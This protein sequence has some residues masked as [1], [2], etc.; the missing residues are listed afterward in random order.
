MRKNIAQQRFGR[1]TAIS[2]T[3]EKKWG[4]FLWHCM[5][6]CGGTHIAAVNSLIAGLVRSCGCLLKETASNNA[7]R[8]GEYGSPTYKSWDS[9][10]QRCNNPNTRSFKNYG[11]RGIS[12]YPPW[13]QYETF[14]KDMGERPPGTSLDRIDVNGDYTPSNCRWATAATQARN[15]R[16]NRLTFDQAETIRTMYKQGKR[17][18]AIAEALGV[19]R[20]QVGSVVYLGNVHIQD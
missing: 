6:D 17:P 16:R 12:V 3:G 18:K 10:M 20:N 7:M 5:C 19:T 15:Q 2:S 1:L 9:M 13:Q 8:H 11:G 14:R 4:V